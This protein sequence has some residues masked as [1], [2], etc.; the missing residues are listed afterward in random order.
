[1]R[2]IF[3]AVL[4]MI[5][6]AGKTYAAAVE[7]LLAESETARQ[8]DQIIL[9]VD[10]N[11]SLWNKIDGSWQKDLESPCNY[12]LNGFNLNRRAG[13]KTTPI[14]A[15]EILYAFGMDEN[16]GTEMKYK[17][18]TPN[19]YL[20]AEDATYNT[21][22]ESSS[23]VAGEHLIDYF[24]EYKYAMNFAFNLNPTVLGR[25]AAIFLHCNST[26][27]DWTSGCVSVPENIMLELLLKAHDGAWIIIVPRPEDIAEY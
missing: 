22:V 5:L 7:N 23:Y 16:P 6:F 27:K 9:V 17:K 13:D 12:G 3:L 19:S 20:S 8:T 14:G 24:P 21:W 4:I 10:H 25:G 18:I 15:F 1:M 26:Y 2:K 11:L